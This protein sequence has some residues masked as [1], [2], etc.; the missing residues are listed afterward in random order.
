M[1]IGPFS[2][3]TYEDNMHLLGVAIPRRGGVKYVF[4][5]PPTLTEASTFE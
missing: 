2:K 3:N 1:S 4:D 5:P